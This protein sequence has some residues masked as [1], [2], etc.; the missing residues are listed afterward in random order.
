MTE[1]TASRRLGLPDLGFGLGLRPPHFGH[2]LRERPPV[3]WFEVVSENFMSSGG[4]PG[5][6]LEL[7]AEAYPVVL[8]GVSMSIG[9][10]DPLDREYLAG[11]K[12]LAERV[13]AV[14][15]SDHLCWTGV[16]G[17]NAH[18]LL[19]LPLDEAS[20]RHVAERVRVVQDLLERP[21]VLENPSAYVGFTA[22]AIPEPEF[23]ARLCDASGCGLLLDVNNVAV[24]CFNDDRDPEEYLRAVP[25]ERVVQIHLAGHTD[26]GT[27]RIDTHDAHVT[28][29]VWR[30][31]RLAWELVGPV[32]TM[33]EWDA[34]I[35]TFDVL[36]AEIERARAVATGAEPPAA[37][38][39]EA[40]DVAAR[41]PQPLHPVLP[42]LG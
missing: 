15:V 42:E 2:V 20:L 38:R 27:H 3:D 14:W 33:I 18:D 12:A 37:V 29:E 6:V 13:R 31:F 10:T 9:S 8:H 1:A 21:L 23:L 11:L 5:R 41:L 30:L 7:V 25:A 28:D 35:P 4:R 39:A 26:L 24:T 22:D 32:S 34:R 36:Q 17:R 40:Q 16:A 19:P